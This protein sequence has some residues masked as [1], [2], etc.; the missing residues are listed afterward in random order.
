MPFLRT[1]GPSADC[2]F[3]RVEKKGVLMLLP[4]VRA[5]NLPIRW[6]GGCDFVATLEAR[7][8]VADSK[9]F[10]VRVAWNGQWD[11]G[12]EEMK[13]NLQIRPA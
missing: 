13:Q 11:D 9:M 4:L 7:S 10:R 6:T 5:N 12:V 8:N 1:I 2:D 3:C